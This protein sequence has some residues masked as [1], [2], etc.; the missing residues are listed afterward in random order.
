VLSKEELIDYLSK[1]L[2]NKLTEEDIEELIYRL[3]NRKDQTITFLCMAI[4]NVEFMQCCVKKR[5]I[6]TKSNVEKL[7]C[8]IDRKATGKI[9][10]LLMHQ[11]LG[12]TLEVHEKMMKKLKESESAL[13]TKSEFVSFVRGV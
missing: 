3:G 5:S 13:L 11:C 10:A 12:G 1:N 7:F 4:H 8:I 9:N 2:T 6:L